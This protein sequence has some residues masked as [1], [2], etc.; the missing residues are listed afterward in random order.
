MIP[1]W[2]NLIKEEEMRNLQLAV[3]ERKIME[4]EILEAFQ[5]RIANRLH[6]KYAIGTSSGSAALA[7]A[8]MGIG[9]KPGDEVIVP[10]ITF[11][12]TANAAHLVG[13][14]VVV[15]P[16]QSIRP[17][18]DCNKLE[19]FIT[20][21]TKAII[22]VHLN[23]RI[24]N[25]KELREKYRDKGIYIIDDACQAFM[26][27]DEYGMA[28]TN[29]D[30]GCFSFGITKTISTIQGGMVVT[31]NEKLF[32]KMKLIKTQ[33][34]RSVFESEFYEMPGF[35]FKL[36][37]AFCAIGMAQLDRMEERMR[38]MQTIDRMY[39]E[40]LSKVKGIRFLENRS[41]EFVWMTDILCENRDKVRSV[42][43]ENGIL[44]RPIG[45]PLH[46]ASFLVS[47]GS[48]DHSDLLQKMILYL[49]SG[50]DQL[51]E[52]IAKTIHVLQ[53]NSLV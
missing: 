28:G 4:G 1:V 52:H 45:V 12:A 50:P 23:G 14:K 43:K 25:S 33:G 22:P 36:P 16:V 29:A 35:N 53:E 47:Y 10:D 19:T 6:V 40:S 8:L 34:M 9:I 41:N 46:T 51:H 37:D 24:V 49:P 38:N 2:N 20:A 3:R 42:L 44:S 27:S 11:I 30:I 13:A 21:K 7:L 39:R 17:L 5:N 32:Q 18:L 31:N 48:Y 26:S 15:A